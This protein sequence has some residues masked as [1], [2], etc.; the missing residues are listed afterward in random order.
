MS[1]H[2]ELKK[3]FS[4]KYNFYKERTSSKDNILMVDRQRIDSTIMNAMLALAVNKKYKKNIIVLSD[5]KKDNLIIKFYKHLGFKKYLSGMNYFQCIK[6]PYL[7]IQSLIISILAVINI[8][9]N[10][11]LWFINNYKIDNIPFGDLI[12]DTNIRFHH[13]YINPKIDYHFIKLL[14]LS[15]FRILLILKYFKKYNIKKIVVGNESYAFNP[16]VALRISIFKGIK[17]YYPGRT[18]DTEFEIATDD[19]Q[20]LFLGRDNIEY[21]PIQ[22]EFKKFR[23]SLK[24]INNFYLSRKNMKKKKY[25]W[26]ANN[27]RNASYQSKK[28][29]DFI[30]K[31]SKIK[32]KK[33]LYASHAF[34]DA[35]HHKGF[36]Y[37]FQDFYN[38][39]VSTLSYVFKN[40]NENIWIFRSHPS[41]KNYNENQVFINVVKR[42]KKKNIYICPKNVSIKELYR[43]CDTVVTGSGTAGL[44]FICEGKQAILAGN[45]AYSSRTVTPYCAKNKKEYFK[46]LKN[47]NSLKKPNNHQRNMARKLIF[48]FESGKFI[49]K[50]IPS[51]ILKRD[52][53]FYT[54]FLNFFGLGLN[55]KD[56]LNLIHS[57]L[58][59][60]IHKSKVFNEMVKLI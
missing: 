29:L 54:F 30:K 28:G 39:F 5:L 52:K 8:F 32:K 59:K 34:S 35:V 24:E 50:K 60:D 47:I 3:F 31:I 41:S 57:V 15:T 25:F 51:D 44:E 36:I 20:K 7:F 23:K 49:I 43:L 58:K 22:K 46:Y 19:T 42:F 38:Q 10:G 37:S 40:D 13:R 6:H 48:F 11:F 21:K 14:I 55:L 16:G 1:E 9:N 17:N 53:I 33:I 56:Y 2:S 4:F 18:S 12:Y 27:F 26:T 45:A